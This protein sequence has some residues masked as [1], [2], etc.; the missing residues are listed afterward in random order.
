MVDS[1]PSYDVE[2]LN[3]ISFYTRIEALSSRVRSL[4]GMSR[5]AKATLIASI[6]VSSLT[7]WGVHYLQQ[8]EH[9]VR[10]P[11]PHPPMDFANARSLDNV[12]GCSSG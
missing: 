8:K 5:A 2:Q 6:V 4:A 7:V 11:F 9:D 3:L 10:M 12:P 1:R